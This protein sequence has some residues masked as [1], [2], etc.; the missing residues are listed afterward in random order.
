[1]TL[2]LTVRHAVKFHSLEVN[3]KISLQKNMM[4]KCKIQISVI[5][6]LDKFTFVQCTNFLLPLQRRCHWW[7]S[8]AQFR[9]ITQT[10]TSITAHFQGKMIHPTFT[11]GPNPKRVPWI[12]ETACQVCSLGCIFFV[13]SSLQV[14]MGKKGLK[15]AGQALLARS[16]WRNKM[17]S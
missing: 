17:A 5:P 13:Y 2:C 6:F 9:R 7:K 8:R 10:S 1:M 4:L 11:S 15:G 16:F 14:D 3:L 12:L